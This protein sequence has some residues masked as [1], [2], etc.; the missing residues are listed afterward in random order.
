MQ[1]S[2]AQ[3]AE[4]LEATFELVKIVR[5]RGNWQQDTYGHMTLTGGFRGCFAG[6]ALIAAGYNPRHLA[7]SWLISAKVD[8]YKEA[9]QYLGL[10]RRQANKLFD[11]D[12]S[13]KRVKRLARKYAAEARARADVEG[14]LF[15]PP[16]WIDEAKEFTNAG[17]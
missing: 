6:H 5:Q 13:W 12:N 9:R 7:S 14:Q 4:R 2:N 15:V 8:V 3:S 11:G 16:N 17:R 1:V 10:T